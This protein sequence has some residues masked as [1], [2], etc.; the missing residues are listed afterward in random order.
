VIV[1]AADVAT[2]VG[3]GN[4]LVGGNMPVL[5]TDSHSPASHV[6]VVGHMLGKDPVD[7]TRARSHW[8]ASRVVAEESTPDMAL[9]TL[10]V[11]ATLTCSRLPVLHVVAVGPGYKPDKVQET[12]PALVRACSRL[13]AL[14]VAEVIELA[15]SH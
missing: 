15:Y 7:P 12:L 10:S 3:A 2:Q 5:L 13:P 8:A 9:A 1:V 4:T 6:A 14:H 11:L